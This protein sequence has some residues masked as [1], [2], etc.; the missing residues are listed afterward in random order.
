[1]RFPSVHLRGV[2]LMRW[3]FEGGKLRQKDYTTAERRVLLSY[4]ILKKFKRMR[5][6]WFQKAISSQS[7][8]TLSAVEQSATLETKLQPNV[9]LPKLKQQKP[10][11]VRSAGQQR[12][13][14]KKG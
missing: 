7:G 14:Q 11:G 5:G 10:S 8:D 4:Y 12:M 3:T 9:L 13:I 1:M 2:S 6:R